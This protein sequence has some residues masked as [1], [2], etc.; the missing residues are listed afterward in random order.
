[1]LHFCHLPPPVYSP[2]QI[3]DQAIPQLIKVIV[4]SNFKSFQVQQAQNANY[5]FTNSIL[6]QNKQTKKKTQFCLFPL[7]PQ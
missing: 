4:L 2:F 5:N 1:M 3:S 6:P 7:F